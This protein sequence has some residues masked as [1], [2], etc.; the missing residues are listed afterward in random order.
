MLALDVVSEVTLHRRAVRTVRT[1][2]RFFSCMGSDMSVEIS[3][4]VETLATEGA[5]VFR[6]V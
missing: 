5:G 1:F 2:E 3:L 4:A 6:L